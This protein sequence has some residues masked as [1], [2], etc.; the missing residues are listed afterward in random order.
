M[1][2]SGVP[3]EWLACAERWRDLTPKRP[4]AKRMEFSCVLAAGRW[5]AQVHPEVTRPGQWTPTLAAEYVAAVEGDRW[6]LVCQP[7]KGRQWDVR[8]TVQAT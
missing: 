5:L 7:E 3:T 1:Y 4:T 2:K 8:K 6:R